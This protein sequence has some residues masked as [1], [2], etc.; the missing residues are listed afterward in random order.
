MRG[1]PAKCRLYARKAGQAVGARFELVADAEAELG[2]D[3]GGVG[4]GVE[5]EAL[6]VVGADDHGEGVFE[7]ERRFDADVVARGVERADGGEDAGGSRWPGGGSG[8][9]RM[10]VSAVP[11]YST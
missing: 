9:L 11:V 10:A 4:D 3:A 8:C 2:G 5:V 6:G 1:G 7:A